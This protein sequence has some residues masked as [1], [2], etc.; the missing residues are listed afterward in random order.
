[1]AQRI[2]NLYR[3]VTLPGFYKALSGLLG[4]ESGRA[5]FVADLLKPKPGMKILDCGCG[6]APLFPY[7]SGTDYTG[8]DINPRHIADARARFGDKACFIVG[9]VTRDLPEHTNAFDLVLVSALLHHLDDEE[10]D[11]LLVALT[12]MTK[13]GGRIVTIDSI[14]LPRQNPIA[15][16]LN[17]LD[18]G[19]NV[20]TQAGYLKLVSGLPLGV[21]TRI[22]RDLM[23]IPYDHFCMSLT[24]LA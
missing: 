9:D 2:S 10:A 19:M 13:F 4:G 20:R 1:M 23:R 17:K 7:L 11:R 8:I 18:S 14:W 21:E 5:R 12:Q 16:L 24:K 15:W 22:Y 6:P 3:L